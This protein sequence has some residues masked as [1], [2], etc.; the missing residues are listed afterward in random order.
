MPRTRT[1]G[2][3]LSD[4][5]YAQDLSQKELAADLTRVSA[6]RMSKWVNDK[7]LP[8]PNERDELAARLGITRDEL[9][10]LCDADPY[11]AVEA[12]LVAAETA[13]KRAS[14][15][16]DRLRRQAG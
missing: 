12:Q 8:R 10:R 4:W 3:Y 11:A 5:L 15:N 14:G 2:Q 16:L 9:N 13:L 1:L 7:G 6:T